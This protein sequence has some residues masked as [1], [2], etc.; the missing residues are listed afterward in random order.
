MK[1]LSAKESSKEITEMYAETAPFRSGNFASTGYQK[2][3]SLSQLDELLNK[4]NRQYTSEELASNVSVNNDRKNMAPWASQNIR[5]D[6]S[7]KLP[8]NNEEVIR[9]YK[10]DESIEKVNKL[11]MMSSA[12]ALSSD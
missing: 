12:S 10:K 9:S 1:V 3:L 4:S 6:L 11:L 7:A 8:P 2:E 5:L